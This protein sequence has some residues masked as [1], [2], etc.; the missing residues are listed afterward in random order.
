[1]TF[2]GVGHPPAAEELEVLEIARVLQAY[3][4]T[5]ARRGKYVYAR[6]ATQMRLQEF[7]RWRRREEEEEVRLLEGHNGADERAQV[8]LRT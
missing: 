2:G 8:R 5:L 7:V 3:A 6:V 4:A 1:M